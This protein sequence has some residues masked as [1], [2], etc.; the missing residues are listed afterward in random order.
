MQSRSDLAN[1]VIETLFEF[2]DGQVKLIPFNAYSY[3]G[4]KVCDLQRGFYSLYVYCDI[5]EPTVVGDV[6][7]LLL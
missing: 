3:T 6:K 7:V 1:N 5:V 4:S 2:S